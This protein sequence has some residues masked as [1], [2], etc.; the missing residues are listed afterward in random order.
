M[1]Y[2]SRLRFILFAVIAIIVL[3]LSSWGIISIARNILSGS[4]A[5]LPEEKKIV[6]ADYARPNTSVKLTVEGPIVADENFVS[7]EIEVGQDFR[8]LTVFKGYGK[9]VVLQKS[10]DNNDVSY[11]AFMKALGKAGYTSKNRAVTTDERGSCAAGNRHVY[12]LKDFEE[13]VQRLWGTS[14]ATR[15][16]SFAGSASAVRALYKAQIPEFTTLIP[17]NPVLSF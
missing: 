10:F 8:R 4:N 15:D 14:C 17:A 16:G 9:T 5:N 3:V 6:L 7:Y 1:E 11:E 13:Q 12:E 2:G